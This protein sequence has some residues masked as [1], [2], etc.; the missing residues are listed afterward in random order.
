[1]KCKSTLLVGTAALALGVAG[2][3]GLTS[4][5]PGGEITFYGQ[6]DV[7]ID[8]TTKG[9]ADKIG[10]DGFHPIGNVGWMP[11]L[12]TNLSYL[13]VRG[14]QNIHD[15]WKF[16]YQLETGIEITTSAG[17]AESNS[18]ESNL[19]RGGLTSRDSYVGF[20]SPDWGSFL[21]GKTYAPYRNS[22]QMMNPFSGMLGDYQLV[23]GNTGGDNRVEFGTRLDHAIW[24]L[25]PNWHG[26]TFAALPHGTTSPSAGRT[27]FIRL[28]IRDSITTRRSQPA[29]WGL[30]DPL[31]SHPTLIR[32]ICSRSPTSAFSSPA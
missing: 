27:P 31:H 32:R 28:A 2:A 12:S 3:K 15:G 21:I 10:P 26:L 14:S 23:M 8:D 16:V 5:T 6:L 24:W 7:S 1:M 30:A 19:V 4:L 17:I 20:S 11:A 25:S 9:I 13:G 18:N 29:M 22:T